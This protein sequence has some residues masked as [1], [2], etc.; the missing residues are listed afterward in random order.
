MSAIL[1]RKMV[2]PLEAQHYLV[3]TFKSDLQHMIAVDEQFFKH[4]KKVLTDEFRAHQGAHE[5]EKNRNP[6]LDPEDFKHRFEALKKFEY[7]LKMYRA[8]Y[9]AD[10]QNAILFHEK[11]KEFDDKALDTQL[12]DDEKFN[13]LEIVSAEDGEKTYAGENEVARFLGEHFKT[14]YNTRESHINHLKWLRK[15][16]AMAL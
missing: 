8:L 4:E 15:H 13:V 6:V 3:Q 10:L 9:N 14:E 11:M 1:I 7:G 16:C 2:V 5:E 12:F